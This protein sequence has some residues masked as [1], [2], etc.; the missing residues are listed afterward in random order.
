MRERSEGSGDISASGAGSSAAP[1]E[2]DAPPMTRAERD[3]ATREGA[4]SEA[5]AII[6][7]ERDASGDGVEATRRAGSDVAGVD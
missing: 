5:R 7:G 6:A 4:K 3:A 2:G 1:A